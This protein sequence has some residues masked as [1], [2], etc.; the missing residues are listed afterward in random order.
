LVTSNAASSGGGL[1]V[2]PGFDNV[3]IEN[4]VICDNLPDQISGA[5]TDLGG[6]TLCLCPAD[7][8]GNGVVNGADLAELL[9]VWGPCDGGACE[10]AD[11]TN[12]GVVNGADLTV[13]LGNW[14]PC[15]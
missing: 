7:L 1:W 15:P 3:L 6:N 9:A 10:D 11:L 13:M 8:T 14:G 2:R 4:S 12:D 5:F